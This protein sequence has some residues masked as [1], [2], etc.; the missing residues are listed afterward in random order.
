MGGWDFEG[1]GGSWGDRFLGW[2]DRM[3]RSISILSR[4]DLADKFNISTYNQRLLDRKILPNN[5]YTASSV[6]IT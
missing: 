3:S 2:C 5:C 6:A 1:L 4:V